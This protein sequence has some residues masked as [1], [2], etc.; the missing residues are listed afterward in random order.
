[1]KAPQPAIRIYRFRDT[2]HFVVSTADAVF[3][4]FHDRPMGYLSKFEAEQAAERYILLHIKVGV[5]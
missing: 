4:S 3:D 2:W 1:M 5:K